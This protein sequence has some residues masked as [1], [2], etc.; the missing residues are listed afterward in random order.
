[1]EFAAERGVYLHDGGVVV[2]LSAVVGSREDGDQSAVTEELEALLHD[3]VGSADEIDLVLLAESGHH[4]RTKDIGN[5]SFIG[6]PASDS[7]GIRPQEIAE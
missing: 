5:A 6:L 1:M 7:L 4:V 3:L 2:E